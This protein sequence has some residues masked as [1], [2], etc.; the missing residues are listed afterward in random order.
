MR[1]KSPMG[2]D[3]VGLGAILVQS[4]DNGGRQTKACYRL[5]EP[6]IKQRGAALLT[7][8]AQSTCHCVGL[9]TLPPL[10]IQKQ[11]QPSDRSQ[12]SG[13]NLEQFETGATCLH[14]EMEP[15]IGA[16]QLQSIMYRTGKNNPADCMS[17]HPDL[18]TLL[19]SGRREKV[20]EQYINFL[21]A[22]ATPKALTLQEIKDAVEALHMGQW[23]PAI[24]QTPA[25]DKPDLQALKRVQRELSTNSDGMLLLKGSQIILPATLEQRVLILAHEGHQGVVK[26]KQ[27]LREKVWFPGINHKVEQTVK[28]CIP[29]QACTPEKFCEPV[30]M[31]KLPT[32]QW[33]EVSID[34][35]GPYPSG[36]YLLVVSDDYS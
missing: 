30:Q 33:S 9:R 29:C 13:T 15:P 4:E 35:S 5:W 21:L 7:D 27:L 26:A 6:S 18:Q 19:T 14:R 23:T 20:A 1:C 10:P 16:L 11:F 17:C 36:K 2:H 31:S 3:T 24:H 32:Q 22:E 12:T 28:N 8:R 25:A 34:F